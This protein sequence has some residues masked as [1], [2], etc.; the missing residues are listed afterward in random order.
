MIGGQNTHTHMHTHMHTHKNKHA[1]PVFHDERCVPRQDGFK[2]E[3]SEPLQQLHG[4]DSHGFD[5]CVVAEFF[6]VYENACDA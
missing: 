2:A 1:R 4:N 6:F 5:G 3:N